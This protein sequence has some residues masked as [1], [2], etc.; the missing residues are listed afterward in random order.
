MKD[1]ERR[2]LRWILFVFVIIGVFSVAGAAQGS[3]F[4]WG[5]VPS[6]NRGNL[7]NALKGI[8]AVSS[9]DIWAVGEFNP[10]I[11][12]TATGRRTLIEHW[13]GSAW[14]IVPSP[15][16]NWQGLDFA[17]LEA[18]DDVASNDVWAVGYSE[19]F[20]SLR[21]N[22]LTLHWDGSVWRG[23]P[24][25]N[26]AGINNPN[27]LFG[28]VALATNNVW[29]VGRLGGSPMPLTMQWNG[30]R[31]TVVRN[32]C[33]NFGGLNGVAAVS[34]SDIWAVGDGIS[35]HYNGTAWTS[36]PIPPSG[37]GADTLLDV[38]ASASNNI[39]AAGLS[40][41]CN[42]DG[43]CSS[44]AYVIRWNGTQWQ[45]VKG[46]PGASLNAVLAQAPSDV[47]AVGTNN[48][49][50]VVAHWDGTTWSDV[51]SPDPGSGGF[52]NEIAATAP[53]Q[54]WAVGSYF[55]RQFNERTLVEQSPSTTQG[56]LVGDTSFAQ[57]TITWIGPQNG[58]TQTD[59]FGHYDAAGLPAGR[60][61]VIASA[62][63]CNPATAPVTISAGQTTVQNF[64]FQCSR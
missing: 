56:S 5:T 54:F 25:P 42:P 20:G 29:A 32:N 63:G 47:W 49:G 27:Q 64:H 55:D 53:N 36:F 4:V 37:F 48:V 45:L 41:Y 31:W 51:P 34:A 11:P 8:T 35:C 19:D 1:F 17:T 15:N 22:T 10:G 3:P 13:D 18:V 50:T 12:P 2:S 57:A 28:V 24:S 26:P 59:S 62:P 60:Y 9:S 39:W 30:T 23:V 21:L 38:S 58:S 43:G 52:L 46:A 7:Q 14:T 33:G 44:I 40:V 61:N 6:P 16:P